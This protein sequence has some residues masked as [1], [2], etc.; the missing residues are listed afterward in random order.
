MACLLAHPAASGL[1]RGHRRAA[2]THPGHDRWSDLAAGHHLDGGGWHGRL[3]HPRDGLGLRR[4]P[5]DSRIIPGRP[6]DGVAAAGG[7]SALPGGIPKPVQRG[8]RRRHLFLGF[9][10]RPDLH[11]T[12]SCPRLRRTR[13]LSGRPHPLG[14]RRGPADEHADRAGGRADIPSRGGRLRLE[15]WAGSGVPD[16]GCGRRPLWSREGW[17]A[18]SRFPHGRPWPRGFSRVSGSGGDFARARPCRRRGF[19]LHRA[20]RLVALHVRAAG[21]RRGSTARA[22]GFLGARLGSTV[23]EWRFHRPGGRDRHGIRG[24]PPGRQ[25]TLPR[26]GW[27]R[28]LARPGR[29]LP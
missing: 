24:P 9:R 20:R 6:A 29:E 13:G 22:G 21:Q 3:G 23:L 1:R 15:R 27:P 25:R 28:H 12:G 11:G 4:L 8:R 18:G 5:S 16:R 2:G 7:G 26:A 14:S 17:P 19:G 10:R